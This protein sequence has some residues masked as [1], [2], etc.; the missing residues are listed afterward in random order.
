MIDDIREAWGWIGIDPKEVVAINPF[1]N[2]LIRDSADRYWRL[3][4]EDVYC[5]VVADSTEEFSVLLDDEEF[6]L[7]WEMNELFE[8]ARATVGPLKEGYRYCL[9]IPGILGGT[10]RGD[11]LASVPLSEMIGFSGSLAKQV[12]DLPDGAEIKLEFVD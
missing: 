6:L 12:K 4:P 1:G 11:N 7:D 9:K 3:C 2:L 5:K 8:E 10:Y